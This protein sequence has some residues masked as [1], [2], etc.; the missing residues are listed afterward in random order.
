MAKPVKA[1]LD[2]EGQSRA[3]GLPTP[4]GDT[5]AATKGYVDG[6]TPKIT[7]GTTAPDSPAVG[8]VWI[9]TN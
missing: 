9:D 7:A 8:D 2:F 5:E 1:D 3:T 6:R 4:I